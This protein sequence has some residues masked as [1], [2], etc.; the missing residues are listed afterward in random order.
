MK[1]RISVGMVDFNDGCINDAINYSAY[2]IQLSVEQGKRYLGTRLHGNDN[3]GCRM[4]HLTL[5]FNND[6]KKPSPP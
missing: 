5:S 4:V 6:G 3:K 1:K 2:F